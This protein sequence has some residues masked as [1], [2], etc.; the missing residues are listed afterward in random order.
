MRVSHLEIP[1]YL[2][3]SERKYLLFLIAAPSAVIFER[4]LTQCSLGSWCTAVIVVL[5]IV[6]QLAS[7]A[8][9]TAVYLGWIILKGLGILKALGGNWNPQNS[10]RRTPRGSLRISGFPMTECCTD[11]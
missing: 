2:S 7:Q 5:C 4:I 6:L 3:S 11:Y 10:R 1:A 8:G 9:M